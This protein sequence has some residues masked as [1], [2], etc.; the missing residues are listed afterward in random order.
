MLEC[1]T[2]GTKVFLVSCGVDGLPINLASWRLFR[3]KWELERGL[4]MTLVFAEDRKQWERAELEWSKDV[5]EGPIAGK[6]WASL[7]L[8]DLVDTSADVRLAKDI[9]E[10][11]ARCVGGRAF[12]SDGYHA[13]RRPVTGRNRL[14]KLV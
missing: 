5:W 8:E 6:L 11:W 7:S 9:R 1:L 12:M 10:Q 3:Q 14:P 13:Q 2:A 4:E